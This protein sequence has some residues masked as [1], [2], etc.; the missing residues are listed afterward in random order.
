LSSLETS[1]PNKIGSEYCTISEAQDKDLQEA[2]VD[3]IMALKEEMNKFLKE[4]C[5]NLVVESE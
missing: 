3:M 4:I 2:F 5:V 1:N